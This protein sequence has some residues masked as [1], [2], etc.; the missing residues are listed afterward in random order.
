[1]NREERNWSKNRGLFVAVKSLL[2]A[3]RVRFL[4]AKDVDKAFSGLPIRRLVS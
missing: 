3:R 1:V 4:C 2:E